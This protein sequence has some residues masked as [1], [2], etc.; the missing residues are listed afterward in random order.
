MSELATGKGKALLEQLEFDREE[1]TAAYG[2]VD[3]EA[4]AV[5]EGLEE[6]REGRASAP[7]W[8]MLLK[9]MDDAEIA[10]E[11]IDGLKEELMKYAAH[12]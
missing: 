1:I 7:T 12:K 2:P 10:K 6:W 11:H 9:A 8:A 4:D 3:K 5:Q